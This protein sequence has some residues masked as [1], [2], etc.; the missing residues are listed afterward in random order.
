MAVLDN[1]IVGTFVSDGLSKTLD[2]P[3]DVDH[4]EVLNQTQAAATNNVGVKYEWYR[5]MANGSQMR[6]YKS[7]GGNALNG[8]FETTRG[9]TLVNTSQQTL[10]PVLV[11]SGITNASPP[12]ASV[13]ST[14]GLSDG[15]I[16][17]L[18]ASTGALQL[19]GMDFTIDNLVANTS[20]E[21]IYMGAPGSAATAGNFQRVNYDAQF[22]P[23]RRFIT[24]ITRASSAVITM[25]VTHGMTVGQRVSFVVPAEYAM[26]E[27]NGLNGIITAINTTTNT[28]TV[29]INS[30]AF[31]AF[32]FPATGDVP[33]TQ[34]QVVPFGD[35]PATLANPQG[36]QSVLD[37]ATDNLAIRGVLLTA[38][39]DNP[40]GAAEDV[41]YWK[42]VKSSQYQS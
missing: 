26:T 3:C 30:T 34:A 32:S 29:N 14:A 1:I 24:N 12:V 31:T 42:A 9:F 7:G 25:S 6:Y 40:G 36:N 18:T 17:R 22:Y 16:V 2:I 20:F 38:G 23:R 4:I 19:A 10:G 11:T 5:G 13:A 27:M 39:A 15:D 35:A 33:F 21:L 8:L 28:I 41:M 37:G